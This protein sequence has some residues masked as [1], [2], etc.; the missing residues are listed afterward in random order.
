MPWH[1]GVIALFARR[2]FSKIFLLVGSII[3][4][5]GIICFLLYPVYKNTEAPVPS[6][7]DNLSLHPNYV[8]IPNILSPGNSLLKNQEVTPFKKPEA[9]LIQPLNDGLLP[10][11]VKEEP[12]SDSLEESLRPG[13]PEEEVSLIPTHPQETEMLTSGSLKELLKPKPPEEEVS[14]TPSLPEE[15]VS[16]TPSLPEE[17]HSLTPHP[18][19]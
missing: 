6:K 16:L 1:T 7:P 2:K 19:E 12:S 4:L 10:W 5:G 13:P 14:L 17:E 3:F 15:E 9:P 11:Q 18:P 8:S